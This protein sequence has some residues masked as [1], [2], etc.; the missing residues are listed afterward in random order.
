[1]TLADNYVPL[2]Y[3]GN[4]STTEW[5]VTWRFDANSEL[6]C[7]LVDTDG[8]E[9]TLAL[10]THYTVVG[11]GTGSGTVTYPKVTVPVT[12]PMATDEKLII[13]RD[14]GLGQT[15]DVTA[16]GDNFYNQ[17]ENSLDVAIMK[18]QELE[19]KINRAPLVSDS[20]EGDIPD[21]DTIIASTAIVEAEGK[22]AIYIRLENNG[23]VINT[24]DKKIYIEMP[25]ALTLTSARLFADQSS[26]V[27]VDVWKDTYANFPP[28]VADTIINTGGGGVKPVLSSTQK[29]EDTGL[30]GWSKNFNAGD[31]LEINVDS[32]TTIT[33]LIISLRFDKTGA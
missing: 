11:A 13:K 17:M 3:D 25:F 1:M 26:S 19:A 6:V 18:S 28:T 20:Y 22:G 23:D 29:Y 12:D 9:S 7:I 16:R 8:N 30:V 31:I 27:V 4:D 24:G 2:T 15:N 14:S 33:V 5:S 10:D 21:I 32:A